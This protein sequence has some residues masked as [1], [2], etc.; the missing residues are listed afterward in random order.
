[1]RKVDSCNAIRITNNHFEHLKAGAIHIQDYCH[2]FFLSNNKFESVN[3]DKSFPKAVPI[4]VGD[5]HRNFSWFGGFCVLNQQDKSVP[6]AYIHGDCT[7]IIGVD[8]V[9]PKKDD[10]ASALNLSPGKNGIGAV[11][12]S[13]FDVRGDLVDSLNVPIY[14]IVSS[15][16]SDFSGSTF[17][18]F[19]PGGLFKFNSSD[20]NLNAVSIVGIG[21]TIQN[22]SLISQGG[23]NNKIEGLRYSGIPYSKLSNQEVSLDLNNIAMLYNTADHDIQYGE[24]VNGAIL[25]PASTKGTFSR[26]TISGKWRC[27]GY[28]P[29]GTST[30]FMRVD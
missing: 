8:F 5:N 14:P 30:I 15:G 21:S 16:A 13:H 9:T 2:S 29:V 22:V 27:M 23:Y 25:K 4:Y 18:I 6:Y 7:R 20:N 1:M 3:I 28:A 19:N 10:G 12:Q 11:I 24:D 26:Y 17:K